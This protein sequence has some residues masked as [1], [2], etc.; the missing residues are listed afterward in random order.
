MD[1]DFKDFSNELTDL[2]NSAD[3]SQNFDDIIK[4]LNTKSI[5]KEFITA[6]IIGIDTDGN[7]LFIYVEFTNNKKVR[8]IVGY[9]YCSYINNQVILAEEMYDKNYKLFTNSVSYLV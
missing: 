4:S 2:L 6:K 9:F 8:S 5:V 1:S 3:L 7:Y